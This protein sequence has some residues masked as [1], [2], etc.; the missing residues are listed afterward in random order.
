MHS[1]S[2]VLATATRP[3]ITSMEA[4][5]ASLFAVGIA[6]IGDRSLFLAV[7]LGVQ[8]KRP[9]PV[10]WGMVV[11]LFTNQALSALLGVWLFSIIS[12]EWQGWIVGSVFV[13]MAF[14]MLIPEEEK[15]FKQRSTG[16]I[17]LASALAFFLL[18]MADKTQLAVIT[19]AGA[20]EA[21]WPVVAGATLGI[22]A[23]TTPALFLG[24]RFAARLP[25]KFIKIFACSLFLLIGCW[26]LLDTAGFLPQYSFF[27]PANFFEDLR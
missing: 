11:G 9:W 24:C 10:F 20:F 5:L 19:L 14:W 16:S 8:F 4:F 2:L 3:W 18:E 23:V 15:S 17:F 22:L 7:L 12:P 6:E 27:Q 21:F 13:I 26:I 1:V 25:M